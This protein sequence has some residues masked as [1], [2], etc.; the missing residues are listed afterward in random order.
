[1]AYMRMS[2]VVDIAPADNPY[3]RAVP[4]PTSLPRSG[5]P[6][7]TMHILPS[8]INKSMQPSTQI[9]LMLH[10]IHASILP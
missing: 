10:P 8:C 9:K 4:S 1:M 7:M 5:A 2:S 6:R 3:R